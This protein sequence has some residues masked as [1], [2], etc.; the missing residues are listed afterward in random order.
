MPASIVASVALNAE[1]AY[2]ARLLI[3]RCNA[4]ESLDLPLSIE[5][6]PALGLICAWEGIKIVGLASA[7]FNLESEICLCVAPEQRRSGIGRRLLRL[8]VEVARS[9]GA[10]SWVLVNDALS[11]SGQGFAAALGAELLSAE[12]RMTLDP[13]A[14]PPAPPPMSGLTCRLA[15]PADTAAIVGLLNTAFGDPV[16]LIERF[17]KERIGRCG[18]RFMIAELCRRPVATLRL[19]V[20]DGWSY[21]TTFGVL[22]AFQGRGIGRR[23]LSDTIARLRVEGRQ[24]QRIEVDTSNTR[25][26]SLYS[27]CGFVADRTFHYMRVPAASLVGV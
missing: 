3:E 22:P 8:A 17:V 14:V 9:R 19:V 1:Q 11:A 21:I 15:S 7:S 26:F 27:S 4:L 18:Q 25:A 16:D 20:D 6:G 13:A 5:P 24:R 12:H 23:L 2:E 10:R